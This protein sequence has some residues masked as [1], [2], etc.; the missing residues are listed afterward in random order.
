[1]EGESV[2]V[3]D[4]TAAGALPPGMDRPGPLAGVRIVDLTSVFLG[5]YCT[6]M[7]GDMGADV[8]KVEPPEGDSTRYLGPARHPSMSGIFITVNRNK[9]SIVVDLKQTEGRAVLLDLICGADMFVSNVRRKALDRLGLAYRDLA[10]VNPKI[11]YCNA[12]GYAEGGPCEDEPAFD[13]IVQANCGIAAL[14]AA[15][16][17]KPTYVANVVADK[18]TGMMAAIALLGALRHRDQTGRGQKV[19]VPM[20]ESMVSFTMAEHLYGR[21][22]VP[23][24]G[25]TVYPRTVSPFRRPYRTAD[26]YIAVVPYNDKQWL[27]FFELIGR[28]ELA[29]DPRF[30]TIAQRTQNI[31]ALYQVLDDVVGSRSSA[32]WLRILREHDIPAVPV[33]HPE[34]LFV[35]PQLAASGFFRELQHPSEGAIVAMDSPFRLSDSPVGLRRHAPRLG[36]HAREIMA[37]LGYPADRIAQLLARQT[38]REDFA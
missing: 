29:S 18:T 35:D 21:T 17:G 13:D 28:G 6:L 23:P 31:D 14:Q 4:D 12:V 16:S 8:I 11:I 2:S 26:G 30:S 36:E 9:R 33:Q 27:R 38:V 20:F 32:D 1:M 24:I 22:F 3:H 7:L 37:E 25:E 5:P 34:Q 15:F 19:E 10:E